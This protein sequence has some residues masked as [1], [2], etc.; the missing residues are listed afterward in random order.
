MELQP[1]MVREEALHTATL[2]HRQVV[3]DDVELALASHTG[4]KALSDGHDAWYCVAVRVRQSRLSL[5]QRVDARLFR[6]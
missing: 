6:P 3:E 1:R 4:E 5:G 2:V